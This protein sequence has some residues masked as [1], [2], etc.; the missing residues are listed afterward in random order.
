[1]R[2]AAAALAAI[3]LPGL[4]MAD[5]WDM[6]TVCADRARPTAEVLNRLDTDGWQELATD[7]RE[8]PDAELDPYDP[9][10]LALIA[11][12]VD[13]FFPMDMPDAALRKELDGYLT[14]PYTTFFTSGD[15]RAFFRGNE[16]FLVQAE[17]NRRLCRYFGPAKP[18]D[19]AFL[20]MPADVRRN[21]DRFTFFHVAPLNAHFGSAI[22]APAARL[23]ELLGLDMPD[24]IHL[25]VSLELIE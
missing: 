4:A 15:S 10:D 9:L 20:H 3:C 8:D 12:I 25:E 23:H 7:F 24:Q 16:L 21:K 22:L 17:D 19:I 1:M 14:D 11:T 2:M 5:A 6:Y 13:Q 18:S